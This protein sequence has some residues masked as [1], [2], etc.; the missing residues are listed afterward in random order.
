MIEKK[1]GKKCNLGWN[2]AILRKWLKLAKWLKIRKPRTKLEK[3]TIYKDHFN[4]IQDEIEK[5]YYKKFDIGQKKKKITKFKMKINWV[6][7]LK[8]WKFS[9]SE[10]KVVLFEWNGVFHSQLNET[11]HFNHHNTINKAPKLVLVFGLKQYFFFL[12]AFC[13]FIFLFLV[14]HVFWLDFSHT[15]FFLPRLTL[16]LNNTTIC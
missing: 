12:H 3:A 15:F 7:F 2:L 4:T 10:N 14:F 16:I 1:K 8:T 13:N 5:K 9:L 11:V 6:T